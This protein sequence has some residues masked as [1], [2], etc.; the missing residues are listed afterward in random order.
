MHIPNNIQITWKWQLAFLLIAGLFL[1][2]CSNTQRA[3]KGK[4]LKNRSA[5]AIL[6]RYQ[7][8]IFE[9]E[10]VGMK[11]S[12]EV[13]DG[14]KSQSFKANIRMRKDSVI[15]IS[16]SP[17]L[18]VEVMRVLITQDSIK[19]V[20]KVPGDKHYYIGGFDV[21]SDLAESDLTFQMIQDLLVGNALDLEKD[22]EKYKSRIDDQ[23]YVLISKVNRKLKKVVGGDEKDL[24]PDDSVFVDTEQRRYERLRR[25]AD[26]DELL[27]KRYWLDGL[28]YRLEKTI[29]DDLY[30][31]RSITIEHGDFK[32]YQEQ[33]YPQ[34]TRLSMRS[35]DK[36]QVF[37]FKISRL[38]TNKP[39][40]FPFEIPDDF[41]RKYGL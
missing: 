30:Y 21:L 29:I 6:K 13:D 32:A 26:E 1:G 31:Q 16:I 4:P 20:S 11:L 24:N 28:N 38:K 5:G 37:E 23:Q 39:Y 10:W 25:K 14:E 27:L 19:Y 3:A 7:P 17:A 36:E 34:T 9:F 35:L 2:S 8:N 41:E 33:F 12:A 15:W 40:D 22:E 18:G